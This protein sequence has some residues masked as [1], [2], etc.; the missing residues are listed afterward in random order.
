MVV[1][2]EAAVRAVTSEVLTSLGY[3]VFQAESGLSACELYRQHRDV[4]RVVLLDLTM[5]ELS[6][7]Q[8]LRK[9]QAIDRDVRV[10]VLTGYTEDEARLR[11]VQGELA[12][13]LTKPFVRDELLAT[14][15]AAA[16]RPPAATG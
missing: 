15:E 6:G 1:D 12:G 14:L 4:I 9:L 13:F 2:D 11:F 8:T 16:R 10:V 5:P 7:E 3:E